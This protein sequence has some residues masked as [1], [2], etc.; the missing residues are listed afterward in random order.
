[1]GA[2]TLC[3]VRCWGGNLCDTITIRIN[4]RRLTVL[5][6]GCIRAYTGPTRINNCGTGL[7]TLCTNLFAAD[8]A[9]YRV[10]LNGQ[11]YRNFVAC[12]NDTVRS[13]TYFSLT[14]NYRTGPYTLSNWTVN[15]RSYS[16][17]LPNMEAL[18][19]SMNRWDPT[20]GWAHE[21]T[22]YS[23]KGGNP[24]TAY[25][26]M[27][28]SRN[29]RVIAR[30]SP[31]RQI[32]QSKVALR[33]PNGTHLLT[34]QNLRRN[35]PLDTV[36]VQIGCGI[37]GPLVPNSRIDTIVQVGR[38][39]TVCP[40]TVNGLTTQ[41]TLT[42]VCVQNYRGRA[43]FTFNETTDCVVLRGASMGND[44]ICVR[45]CNPETGFCDTISIFVRV[46]ATPRTDC[47]PLYSGSDTLRV[48]SCTQ[49]GF[50]TLNTWGVDTAAYTFTLDGSVV[51]NY[52]VL[53][54][55]TL[56]AYTYFTL[57]SIYRAPYTLQSWRVG[58]RELSGTFTTM[59][60]LTDSMNRWDIGGGW[61]LDS[62][63]MV[64]RGG[65]MNSSQYGQMKFVRNGFNV[66]TFAPNR[67]YIPRQIAIRVD[68]G[69]HQLVTYNS[70]N[71]CRD[72]VR[73][74]VLCNT[75]SVARGIRN[76][77]TIN[78]V[79]GNT[80]T[81]CLPAH[82]RFSS[83]ATIITTLCRPQLTYMSATV[84]DATDCVTFNALTEGSDSI[85][86]LRCYPSAVCDT[87][88][89]RVNVI[90][91]RPAVPRLADTIVR[92]IALR[93][94]STF[95]L[96]NAIVNSICPIRNICDPN[97]SNAVN[98]IIEPNRPCVTYLADAIG[99]D[100]ACLVWCNANG[101]TDTT[102]LIVHV[103]ER[104]LPPIARDDRG[105]TTKTAILRI[106]SI[107]NDSLWGAPAT[108]RVLTQ[109]IKGLVV[110]DPF[111]FGTFS[112][113]YI[114]EQCEPRDSFTYII[115]N[116]WGAD[117]ATVHIE[118][119]CD[120]VII[121][122][123]FSPNEDNQND[124]FVILGIEKYPNSK[125]LIFNRWGNQVFEALNYKNNWNGTFEGKPLP[126]GT[127]FYMLDLGNGK[128]KAGYLQIHR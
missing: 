113:T 55:D 24:Q 49:G 94:D 78:I 73:L 67:Q 102:V 85:C 11:P 52:T 72:S 118:V 63:R 29:G 9:N 28:F 43:V 14:F 117:T 91:R 32:I 56:T 10:L 38:E 105:T 20:G 92:Y 86:L 57:T 36:R 47:Q 111:N 39:I 6:S 19:D 88:I 125:L 5:D 123:G 65:R 3:L 2:D 61:V 80:D 107:R 4:V 44:T 69:R 99:S 35:C 126:D 27:E 95:C 13:Y 108:I 68:T 79:K 75:G 33:V 17:V 64:I 48:P 128:Q 115:E 53:A 37:D 40:R 18:K 8:T 54:H 114:A 12:G 77:Q 119:I 124:V 109:P 116:G 98:F 22:A 59:R 45:R 104:G 30:F 81:V 90:P 60:Q 16:A 84:S 127:Y 96:P 100:T 103:S 26:N 58:S 34:F 76:V 51:R 93:Q 122:S 121:Y 7:T 21:P 15:G 112:Y 71:G 83:T 82:D 31:N 62:A 1:V 106:N 25:G 70:L 87:F 41:T 101:T 120:D 110:A 42:N 89:I 66:A 50:V 46:L 23:I 97:S 74:T